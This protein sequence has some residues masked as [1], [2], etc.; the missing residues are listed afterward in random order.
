LAFAPQALTLSVA[1]AMLIEVATTTVTGEAAA[2][3]EA[4]AVRA[5]TLGRGRRGGRTE[6][7]AT[8]GTTTTGDSVVSHAQL[9]EGA[10]GEGQA[11]TEPLCC[12]TAGDGRTAGPGLHGRKTMRKDALR[13]KGPVLRIHLVVIASLLL[14]ASD[15]AAQS[16]PNSKRRQGP[17]NTA[18]YTLI[19]LMPQ[20][21]KFWDAAEK[22]PASDQAQLLKRTL[23]DPNSQVYTA[24]VL[25]FDSDKPFDEQLQQRYAKWHDL[26]APRVPLMRRLSTQIA[27][28]LPRYEAKFR[29]TFPDFNYRGEVYF[30]CSFGGFDGATREVKGKTALLFGLDMIAFVYGEKADPQPFFHHEFFHIH[31]SQF[32]NDGNDDPLY[33][34]LWREGLAEYIAKQLNPSAEGIALFGLPEDMPSRAQAM[35]PQLAHELRTKLDSTS[36]DD[37][38]RFFLG[39]SNSTELPSRSGYYVGY[40]VAQRIGN[41]HSLPDLAKMKGPELRHQ[42]DQALQQLEATQ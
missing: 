24:H 42:I 12:D 39:K 18:G 5:G 26:I 41:G 4:A 13:F 35:L 34:S 33:L 7:L 22:V 23:M 21:W 20:F 2:P 6:P 16:M 27:T 38:A 10:G 19:D 25:G 1:R 40:V 17:K 9:W 30:L 37:Y 15:S 32:I 28:D 3:L 14:L 31:H 29:R 11:L 8:D 36:R